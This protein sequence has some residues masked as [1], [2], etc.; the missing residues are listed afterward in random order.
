MAGIQEARVIGGHT[1]RIVVDGV[2]VGYAQGVTWTQDPG[3]QAVTGLGSVEV[4][5][6]Q[7]TIFRVSGTIQRWKIRDDDSTKLALRSPAE[8]ARL[9]VFD[10]EV[11]YEVTGKPIVVIEGITLAGR[12]GGVQAGQLS[13]ETSQ[14][15]AIRLRNVV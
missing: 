7:N 1:A 2:N 4:L 11:I 5:E 6:H 3:T 10:M 13:T 8:S 15:M 14:Y 12:N 9:G